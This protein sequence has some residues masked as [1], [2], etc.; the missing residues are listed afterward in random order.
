[1]VNQIEVIDKIIKED[2]AKIE[3]IKV[4]IAVCKRMRKEF[5]KEEKTN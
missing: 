4:E 1:M 3:A 5:E 2:E